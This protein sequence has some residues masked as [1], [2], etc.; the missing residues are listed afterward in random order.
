MDDYS[1]FT[2]FYPMKKKNE[3]LPIFKIFKTMV[4]KYFG[5]CIKNYQSDGG[6]QCDNSSILDSFLQMRKSCSETQA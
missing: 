4:E 3:A 6:G 2:W 5:T 1:P